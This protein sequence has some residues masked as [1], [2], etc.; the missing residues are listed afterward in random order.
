MANPK[1][2]LWQGYKYK[3]S[4]LLLILPIF[5]LY[6]SLFPKFPDAWEAKKIGSFEIVP[7]P[8]NLDPPYLHDGVY[9]KDFFFTFKQG[10][11]KNIRQAYVN[12]GKHALPLRQL[13]AGNAGI[14]HGSQHGQEAHAISPAVLIFEDKMWLTIEN[15]QGKLLITSWPL[16]ASLFD[17]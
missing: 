6:Q 12:I 2:S 15:W 9:T 1:N 13:A 10:D 11:I 16:P 5:F 8:Y 4:G 7:M 17:K 14:L 3:V